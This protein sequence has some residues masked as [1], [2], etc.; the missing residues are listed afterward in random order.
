[1]EELNPLRDAPDLEGAKGA[2]PWRKGGSSVWEKERRRKEER[3]SAAPG[4][5]S[6]SRHATW[7]D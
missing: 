6:E 3:G 5:L 4:M 1:V 7:H 2:T